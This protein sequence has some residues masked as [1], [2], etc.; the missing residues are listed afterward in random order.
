MY[1]DRLAD[2]GVRFQAAIERAAPD[3]PIPTCPEWRLRDLVHH[4]GGIHRWATKI[5]AER[6]S[7]PLLEDLEIVAGGWPADDDLAAWFRAG[8]ALLLDALRGAPDDAEIWSFLRGSPNGAA[9][10][11]RRQLHETTVHRVD[12]ELASG[13]VSPIAVEHAL[14][15]LDELLNG[16]LP[17]RSTKL[18]PPSTATISLQPTDD[19][20]GWLVTADPD[21]PATAPVRTDDADL[22]V[23]GRASDLYLLLWNRR[24]VD[25][26]EVK[27]DATLLDLWRS[28]V[29]IRFS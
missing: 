23:R 1:L 21:G 7:E 4:T 16:F 12:A 11:S 19:A 9:F 24:D 28:S 22:V 20:A 29:T 13:P 18:R 2:E 5:V 8:H 25:G 10:W 26:L 14:D 15:G 27:G 6:R 3:A 17:R